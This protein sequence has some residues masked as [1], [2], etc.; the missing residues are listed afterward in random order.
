MADKLNPKD[1]VTFEELTLSN[2]WELEALISVLEKK[3]VITKQEILDAIHELRH[4]NPSAV[5][6]Q[7]DGPAQRS[8]AG[9]SHHACAERLQLHGPNGAAGPRSIGPSSGPR[10]DRGTGRE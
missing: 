4:K 1:V 3:G 10:G 5:A 2:V 9:Y 6:P 7:Q 8:E